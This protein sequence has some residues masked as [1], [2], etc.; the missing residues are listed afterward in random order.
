MS[1]KP[2]TN[3][4]ASVHQRLLS[5]ATSRGEEMQSVL[6]RYALERLLYRIGQSRHRPTLVLKG[7]FL[8]VAWEGTAA[9]PT[10]D[11][12][13]LAFGEPEVPRFEEIFRGICAQEAPDDGLA[14]DSSSVRGQPIREAS[15]YDGIRIKLLARLGNARIPLQVDIGFG[16]AIQPPPADIDYPTL[17]DFPAPRVKGYLR[18]TVVAEKFEA[19]VARGSVTSRLKDYYDIWLLSQNF[20][21]DLYQPAIALAATFEQRGTSLPVHTPPCLTRDFTSNPGRIRQW[22]KLVRRFDSGGSV[23]PLETAAARIETFLMPAVNATD[24]R[25]KS[26][27]TWTPGG[28]WSQTPSRNP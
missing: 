20:E 15:R 7:A 23:P 4:A 24:T 3:V 10:K 26:P 6:T 28:P 18:E 14:F 8:F 5:I 13:L 25:P 17:L 1:R 2:A 11:L 9:R 19:M 16:D 21:F 12:D 22:E 27:A